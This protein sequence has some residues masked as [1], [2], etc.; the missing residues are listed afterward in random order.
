MFT[1][2]IKKNNFVFRIDASQ[3]VCSIYFVILG[4]ENFIQLM[5]LQREHLNL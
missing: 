1:F 2:K 4:H 3:S 5:P